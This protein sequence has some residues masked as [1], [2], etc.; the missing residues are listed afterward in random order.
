MTTPS[1]T[2]QA[3]LRLHGRSFH[4]AGRFLPAYQLQSGAQLYH[5]CRQVDDIADNATTIAERLRARQMLCLLQQRLASRSPGEPYLLMVLEDQSTDT[6]IEYTQALPL[7]PIDR[8]FVATLET[9]ICSLF[10]PGSRA[11]HAMQDLITTMTVDLSRLHLTSESALL[12]YAYGA[13]GTVGVMMCNLLD[14]KQPDRALAF[15]IDLG[16]AMQMTNIARDVLEDAHDGRLYLPAAWMSGDVTADQIAAGDDQA[17]QQAWQAIQQL[18]ALAEHYYVSGWQGLA[19]LPARARLA[20]GVALRI[21]RDIGRRIH[22]LNATQYW[23]HRVVVPS[24]AKA[25][26]SI[27]A[28]PALVPA[29]SPVHDET[30]HHSLG[31]T[32]AFYDG[33]SS[34]GAI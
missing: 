20:I 31:R 1:T 18:L 23:G 6:P 15:A 24:L 3:T 33:A 17:R 26:Q 19:Y 21:Y 13:A 32:L 5:V 4:W 30:L 25:Y 11:Y 14:A 28:L 27:L 2:S 9:D 7:S 22:R 10:S 29:K 34:H 8:D 16:I 12:H